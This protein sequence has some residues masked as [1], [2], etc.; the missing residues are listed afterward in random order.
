MQIEE[1]KYLKYFKDIQE[2][3]TQALH[4]SFLKIR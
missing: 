4:Q 2:F 3:L 1:F